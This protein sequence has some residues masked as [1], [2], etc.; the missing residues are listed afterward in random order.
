[1]K[2]LSVLQLLKESKVDETYQLHWATD[3]VNPEL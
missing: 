2:D 1:M 3:Q